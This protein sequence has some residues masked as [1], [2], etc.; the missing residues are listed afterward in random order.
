MDGS[1][2][3][4]TALV[5]GAS[6]GIGRAV[7]GRLAQAGASVVAV[8]R[9]AQRLDEL[10][11]HFRE[12]QDAQGRIL[13]FPA[14]VTDRAA[15]D[16]AVAEALARFGG[17]HIVVCNAGVMPLSPVAELRV[18]D[19]ERMVDVN[20]KGV[21]HTL[22]SALPILL[23]QGSGH[24]VTV[25]SVA[26]RR[27]FPGGTVYAATKFAVRALCW[28]LH[29]ELGAEHGI[30][31]TDVQPGVVRT[32]LLDHIPDPDVRR[33]FDEAWRD[34]HPLAPEDVAEAV[35]FAVTTPPHVSVGEILVRP[36]DQA[37]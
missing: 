33:R 19:W 9:R 5:T 32:E 29:L 16:A 35:H 24:I 12:E 28:G 8:A 23:D 26:G 13:P 25:G 22:G 37:T 20:V 34:R 11:S 30:R 18:E 36:T 10:A 27:P 21:L 2:F 4:R 3:G 31:V 17:L 6:S 15:M 7:A 14:D 1:L